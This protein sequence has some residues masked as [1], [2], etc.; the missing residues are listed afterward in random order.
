MGGPRAVQRGFTLLEIVVVLMLIGI[1]TGFAALS[2]GSDPLK[3]QV[4]SQGRRLAAILGHHRDLAMLRVEQRGVLVS[5]QS[6][7]IM[8]LEDDKWQPVTEARGGD[9]PTGLGLQLSVADLP[10]SLKDDEEEAEGNGDSTDEEDTVKPQIWM[11][12]TGELLPFELVLTDTEERYRFVVE[13]SAGGRIS[14][15]TEFR[16]E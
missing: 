16:V 5:E 15:R 4:D 7:Q 10:A 12:S 8:R 14:S 6:Y 11:F 1:I 9:L 13:G 2:V 3:D